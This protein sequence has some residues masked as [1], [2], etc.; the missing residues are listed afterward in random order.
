MSVEDREKLAR[1]AGWTP[2]GEWDPKKTPPKSFK[3]AD[4]FIDD[5]PLMLVSMRKTL[6]KMDKRQEKMEAKL[7][8]SRAVTALVQQGYEREKRE[9]DRLI[10]QY[11]RDK[12]EAVAE[13]N[14]EAGIQADREISNLQTETQPAAKVNP[15]QQAVVDQWVAANPWYT[16]DPELRDI[17]AELSKQFEAQG[18]PPG[19][20]RLAAV[21]REVRAR[22]PERTASDPILG[23]APGNPRGDARPV[24]RTNGRTFD[25]LPKEAQDA[26]N[27][28]K[29]QNKALTKPQY[30]DQYQWSED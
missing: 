20:A 25:D 23:G 3:T 19:E 8:D 11:E 15:Q 2:E 9:K 5:A 13:G 26:Y 28:F 4:E 24:A 16:R 18:V 10:Q 27:R 14:V 1:D 30:L 17:A 22:Y 21:S 6:E 7:G 29:A 12:A